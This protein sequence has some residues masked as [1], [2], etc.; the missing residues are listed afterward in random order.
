MSAQHWLRFR[1]GLLLASLLLTAAPALAEVQPKKQDGPPAADQ[2]EKSPEAKEQPAP[3]AKSRP[4]EKSLDDDLLKSLGDPA[5][6]SAKEEDPLG[7]IVERMRKAQQRM[8]DKDPGDETRAL[9]TKAAQDLE[10]LIK[11]LQQQ[12][13]QQQQNNSNQSQQ[14]RQSKSEQQS[15]QRQDKQQ[16]PQNSGKP[17]PGSEGAGERRQDQ[18][19]ARN[20]TE[21]TGASTKPTPAEAARRQQM[22]KDVW[23]HLPPALRQE[24]LNTYTDKFLL[25]YDDLVRR[26]YEALAERNK[27]SP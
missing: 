11:L 10:E 5:A 14:P 7:E 26:Y 25:K 22:E 6:E 17:Q 3:P 2:T 12:Q 15:G 4:K 23:G 16:Q 27:R 21:K 20:S 8:R 24:M 13:Q 18:E 9:Q 19:K 1:V